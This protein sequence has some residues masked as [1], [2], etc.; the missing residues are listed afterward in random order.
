MHLLGDR[1]KVEIQKSLCTSPIGFAH[2]T[3]VERRFGILGAFAFKA[4]FVLFFKDLPCL[5]HG[6]FNHAVKTRELFT[7]INHLPQINTKALADRT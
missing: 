3:V 5:Q 1:L 4:R 7:E 2:K 6:T